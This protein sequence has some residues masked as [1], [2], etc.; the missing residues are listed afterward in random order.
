M[1]SHEHHVASTLNQM[2]AT[3]I[4][5]VCADLSVEENLVTNN[6]GGQGPQLD[7]PPYILMRNITSFRGNQVS[8]RIENSSVYRSANPSQNRYLFRMFQLNMCE[9]ARGQRLTISEPAIDLQCLECTRTR[10][11]RVKRAH[12]FLLALIVASACDSLL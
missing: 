9:C 11:I 4:V 5:I 2:R 1:Q 10:R 8:L 12:K 3:M 7:D 6:L